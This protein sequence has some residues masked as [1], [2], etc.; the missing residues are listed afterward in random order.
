LGPKRIGAGMVRRS[1]EAVS[2]PKLRTAVAAITGSPGRMDRGL[3]RRRV[4]PCGPRFVAAADRSPRMKRLYDGDLSGLQDQSRSGAAMA[5]ARHLYNA[6]FGIEE[7]VPLLRSWWET[8]DWIAEKD[9]DPT[10]R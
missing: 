10:R 5:M 7:I 2:W 8:A 6:G 4:K 9:A 3:R 1:A